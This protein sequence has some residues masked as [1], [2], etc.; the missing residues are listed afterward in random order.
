MSVTSDIKT[1][2]RCELS[3]ML[4]PPFYPM[5]G[6]YKKD[7]EFLFVIEKQDDD[8]FY[9]EEI[10]SGIND[11]TFNK[12]ISDLNIDNYSITLKTK[13]FCFDSPSNNNVKA[14]SAWIQKECAAINPRVVI[15]M[16]NSTKRYLSKLTYKNITIP[17]IQYIGG[18]GKSKYSILIEE[19]KEKISEL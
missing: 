14:C 16:G 1:C 11:K 15:F 10:L 6:R 5:P 4:P 9:S 19:I 8:A 12:I 17:S 3:S 2:S 18:L 13:C 7:S